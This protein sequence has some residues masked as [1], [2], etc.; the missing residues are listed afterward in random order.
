MLGRPAIV[1]RTDAGRPAGVGEEVRV[2]VDAA[3]PATRTL[4]LTVL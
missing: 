2:R 1:A 3:D 4:E